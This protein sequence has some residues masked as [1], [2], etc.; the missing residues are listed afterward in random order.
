MF[1][2]V[3]VGNGERMLQ[4]VTKNIYKRCNNY[5]EC[6]VMLSIYI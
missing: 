6:V 1:V 4:F 3:N 5:D 2:K